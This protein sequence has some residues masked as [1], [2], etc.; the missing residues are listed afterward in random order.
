MT[1]TT[2]TVTI[3]TPPAVAIVAPP[4]APPKSGF[5][6]S[7]FTLHLIAILLTALYAS[8]VIPTAGT[9]ATI[10][11]VAATSLGSLGYTVARTW[12]KAQ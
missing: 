3:E 4:A 9:I 11:A 2:A 6:T 10:A 5:H 12:I 1:D 8:G 7:E